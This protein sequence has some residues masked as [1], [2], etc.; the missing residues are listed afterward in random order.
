M[1]KGPVATELLTLLTWG[2]G[3]EIPQAAGGREK[4]L[5]AVLVHLSQTKNSISSV[6]SSIPSN[7]MVAH[8]Q[9]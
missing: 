3:G 2:G 6:L 5:Q 4:L 8:K 9:L 7:H 1:G